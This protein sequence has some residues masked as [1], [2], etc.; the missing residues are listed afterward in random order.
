[1]EF[2]PIGR[3]TLAQGDHLRLVGDRVSVEA[4][5]RLLDKG[6]DK[7]S[8]T[9]MVTFVIGLVLGVA[10]GSIPFHLGSDIEVRLGP[11]GGAFLVSLLL[12][13][14]G[15]IG[16]FRLYVPM[17]AK[18]LSR[19]LGLMLFLAGVGTGAGSRLAQVLADQGFWLPL[20]GAIVTLLAIASATLVAHFFFRMNSLATS[21]LVAASM[22]NSPA[23]T[24][25]KS[26]TD[27]PTIAYAAAY[28][29]ALFTKVV[30]AQ[31]LVEVLR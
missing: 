17:A 13:H 7:A 30:I 11:A 8:E 18:N 21:G 1:V 9:N 10:A 5:A 24:S 28:P 22:T 16:P 19:E 4:F 23:L 3:V 25:I 2:T 29:V 14:F 20:A 6:S 12:G 15:R 26:S 31:V 27:L